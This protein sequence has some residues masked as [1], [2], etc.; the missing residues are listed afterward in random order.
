MIDFKEMLGCG[1]RFGCIMLSVTSGG[2]FITIAEHKCNDNFWRLVENLVKRK[3][4]YY[5]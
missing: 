5:F 2:L 3:I 4:Y 1:K